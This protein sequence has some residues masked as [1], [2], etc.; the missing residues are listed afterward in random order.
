MQKVQ[1]EVQTIIYGVKSKIEQIQ[2]LCKIK[3]LY[4]NAY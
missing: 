2:T 1:I 4:T 3:N